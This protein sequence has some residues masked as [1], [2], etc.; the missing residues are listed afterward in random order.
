MRNPARKT[1]L[2]AVLLTLLC[3][4]QL[5]V[6]ADKEPIKIAYIDPL[7][8]SFA[9]VGVNAL[10]QFEHAI[11]VL[12]NSKG[13][14]LDGRKMEIV[15][16]D[17]KGSALTSRRR[18]REAAD[19][20]I[21]FVLQGN[22]SHVANE[23][24]EAIAKRNQ[25]FPN[26]LMLYL[27]FSANDPALTNEKCDF[28]HFR[29]DPHAE[30]K[31]TALTE[32]IKER[33]DIKRV[34][35][36]DQDYSF[37][38]AVAESATRLLREKRS[39]IEI[40]GSVFHP[41]G[42]VQDFTPYV[43]DIV[44]A[45]PD[46]IITGNW[47]DDVEGLGLAISRA[48]LEVPVFTFYG[49][50][51]GATAAF[52]EAGNN[53]IHL[54]HG[55]TYNPVPTPELREITRAYKKKYPDNDLNSFRILNTIDFLARAIEEAG[56]TDPLAVALAM[57]GMSFTSVTGANVTMRANDHQLIEPLSIS[58]QTDEDIDFDADN[59]GMGFMKVSTIGSDVIDNVPSSCH[60][61]RPTTATV[62]AN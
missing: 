6:A 45:R 8:G 58:V 21:H 18:L 2:I 22:S 47:G 49:A 48:G 7:S 24:I 41:V 14:V 46:A 50:F 23:L 29:F 34:Y 33:K 54:V 44:A 15:A 59:S 5:A 39:D 13:G 55:G 36:I 26:E 57:E 61:T 19:Q 25:R 51:D 31:M 43:D 3:I 20:G 32:M 4:T 40:V 38:H 16:F 52:G 11:D 27:N 42:M 53:L 35:L 37:G 9:S 56:S 28:W 30:M 62:A 60:M 10:N 17:N 1:R 12:V